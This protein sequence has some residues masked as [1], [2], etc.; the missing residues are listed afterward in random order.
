MKWWKNVCTYISVFLYPYLYVTVT[1]M[2][3]VHFS[4]I[5]CLS[6]MNSSLKAIEMTICLYLTKTD[7][8]TFPHWMRENNTAGPDP[9]SLSTGHTEG[10]RVHVQAHP[11]ACDGHTRWL[12]A[13]SP[14]SVSQC[15]FRQ[16]CPSVLWSWQLDP[17]RATDDRD[18]E[19]KTEAVD[20]F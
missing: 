10:W 1:R 15:A 7:M 13:G 9:T 17:L 11:Q 6:N 14:T 20:V 18:R 2:H 5:T 16:D 3:S 4:P 8:G 12:G 19:L